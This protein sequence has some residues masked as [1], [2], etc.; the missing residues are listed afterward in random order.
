MS[1]DGAIQDSKSASDFFSEQ[2]GVLIE[3]LKKNLIKKP[4]TEDIEVRELPDD[5]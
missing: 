3:K 5:S 2:D 4:K 1:D